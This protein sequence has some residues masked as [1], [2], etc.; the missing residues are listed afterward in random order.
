M[1]TKNKQTTN[2]TSVITSKRVMSVLKI[3]VLAFIAFLI[4]FQGASA[5]TGGIK[6]TVID[7]D[8][9]PA[10][11]GQQFRLWVQ[12]ENIGSGTI[13]NLTVQVNASYPFSISSGSSSKTYTDLYSGSKIYNEY[14]LYVDQNATTGP[15]NLSLRY[16]VDGGN[17]VV[18]NYTVY[19]GGIINMDN[20]GTLIIEN[21]TTTPEAFM[22]GDEG[23]IWVTLKNNATPSQS[24]TSNKTNISNARIQSANLYSAD[25]LV[26]TSASLY[27]L[28]IIAPGD[29]ISLP[30]RLTVP[31]GTPDGTY[32]LTLNVTGSS[33]E[34]NIKRNIEVT[35][36]STGI[37]AIPSKEPKMNGTDV[38]VEI[39]IVNYHQGTIRGVVIVPE[40]EGV[41]F[42]P[43][44]YFIGEMKPDDL[45]TAKFTVKQNGTKM[46]DTATITSIYY[47]GNNMH[48]DNAT[49]KISTSATSGLGGGTSWTTYL[50]IIVVIVAI[51]AVGAHFYLKKKKDI[52]L[53][54]Y[55]KQKKDEKFPK[56]KSE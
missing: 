27:D 43:A 31:E 48:E 47:N 42:Y 44:E 34:Y 40:L 45:Y 37:K 18:S 33:Y 5:A 28:G 6:L 54:E 30:F 15:Y 9:Y 12:A 1:E 21:V 36:D 23:I 49:V 51:A 25:E 3:S 38:V 26:V 7:Q 17:W 46:N 39:D 35:V 53:V 8:P 41:D 4:L 22:P 50:I 29:N 24:T 20:Q 52:G 11:P 56:K 32:L 14:F 55:L 16:Q 13:N 2:I 10:Q 19:V